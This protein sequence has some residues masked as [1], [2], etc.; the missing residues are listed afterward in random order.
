MFTI[1]NIHS[2]LFFAFCVIL[3]KSFSLQKRAI[4]EQ[5]SIFGK[6]IDRPVT[7]RDLQEMKYL[8]NIIKETLRLYPAVPLI[9]RRTN[10]DIHFESEYI[11]INV[12]GRLK[13]HIIK[14]FLFVKYIYII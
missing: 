10:K 3:R 5:D 11:I 9:G 1:R 2:L 14:C 7:Y 13:R 6:D 4:E 8:D 12:E